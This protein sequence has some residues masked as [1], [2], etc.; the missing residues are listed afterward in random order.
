MAP[1]LKAA[2][3]H[4]WIG[5]PERVQQEVVKSVQQLQPCHGCQVCVACRMVAIGQ[6]YRLRVIHPEQNGYTCEQI[7]E[8]LVPLT[9]AEDADTVHVLHIASADLLLPASAQRLLKVLEEPPTGWSI[10]LG[11]E[12]AFL[13]IP[14]IISRCVVANFDAEM[15]AISSH[16][17]FAWLLSP[18]QAGLLDALK[19]AD[20]L[21]K[22]PQET[23]ELL[24]NLMGHWSE[25]WQQEGFVPASQASVMVEVL[26][27]L[28]TEL[29]GSGGGTYFWRS[30]VTKI[31]QRLGIRSV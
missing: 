22:T 26:S 16:T 28:Y 15:A 11:A 23:R 6:S 31:V 12:R 27:D 18:I 4:L 29:P 1:D 17:L 13:V 21:P 5:S 8:A 25:K 24:D 20:N 10:V 7:D 2:A 9:F 19:A 30:A 14:T 3:V